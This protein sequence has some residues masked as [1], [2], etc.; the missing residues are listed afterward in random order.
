MLRTAESAGDSPIGVVARKWADT[1]P[2]FFLFGNFM[3][4]MIVNFRWWTVLLG[5]AVGGVVCGESSSVK[6]AA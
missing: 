6:P 5:A 2:R 3:R 4:P 1:G